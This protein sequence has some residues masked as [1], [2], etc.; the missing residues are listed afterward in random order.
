MTKILNPRRS[1]FSLFL[2]ALTQI[3]I[4]QG[5]PIHSGKLTIEWLEKFKSI[6]SE[7]LQIRAIKAKLYNDTLFQDQSGRVVL[8]A[9]RDPNFG[10]CKIK[11]FIHHK[12]E[13]W[14]FDLQ[15]TP[16][17]KNHM[18]EINP[19]NIEFVEVWEGGA[20]TAA[21]FGTTCSVVILNSNRYLIRKLRPWFPKKNP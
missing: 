17:L 14:D 10:H 9:P 6:E 13:Y 4:G 15:Q 16:V 20:K 1:I 18:H 8:D 3:A 7:I 2:V 19:D 11:F 5:K 21:W 12:G